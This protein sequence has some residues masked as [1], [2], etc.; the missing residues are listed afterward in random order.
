MENFSS[1]NA[2]PGGTSTQQSGSHD[3]SGAGDHDEPFCGF[4]SCHFSTRQLARLL[5]V[6][7]EVLEA[8]LGRGRYAGDITVEQR[9]MSGPQP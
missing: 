9:V 4:R 2:A 5:L 7:G 8:K 1:A 3:G 6:R